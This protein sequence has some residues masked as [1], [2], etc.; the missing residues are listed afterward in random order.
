M[1][2]SYF[3][4][5]HKNPS[6]KSC[7]QTIKRILTREFE[8]YGE[9]HHFKQASDFMIY[10]ESLHPSSPGLTRQVQ[11]A[12]SALNLPRDENGY[13]MINKTVEEYKAEQ[14]LS[15]L[16]QSSSVAN[17][18]KCT[19][20]LVKMESWKR[21]HVT[22]LMQSA[23]ELRKLYETIVPAD[24]GILIYTKTPEKLVSFFSNFIKIEP[25]SDPVTNGVTDL[26]E[27]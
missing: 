10:F 18:E 22:Y 8:E 13:F 25:K 20:V 3:S 9:N 14:E 21:D 26:P 7:E 12:V 23:A 15:K 4:S 2:S 5:T 11:R 17:L 16:L 24:N 27:I 6:R 19:P 1:P